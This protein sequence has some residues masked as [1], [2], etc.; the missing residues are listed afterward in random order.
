MPYVKNPSRSNAFINIEKKDKY[1]F[2]WSIS[3]SLHPFGNEHPNRVSKNKQYFNELKI[4]GF[5]FTHGF[6]CS[7]VQKFEKLNNLSINIFQ[8]IFYQDK[9][10]CKT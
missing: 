5:D 9:H 4:N 3:A 10:K 1:C 2:I 8:L 6:I 7:D